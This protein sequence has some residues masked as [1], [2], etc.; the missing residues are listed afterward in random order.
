[1]NRNRKMIIIAALLLL[2]T[3]CLLFASC[4]LHVIH[5]YG[6][7]WLSD[8]T[9]HWKQCSTCDRQTA[10]A[11]H[12][13]AQDGWVVM[14]EP[15]ESQVGYRRGKCSVCKKVIEEEIEKIEHEHN[16][17]GEYKSDDLGHWQTCGCGASSDFQAHNVI[18]WEID[19]EATETTSGQKHG[20]CD[21]CG[22]YVT[23][24]IPIIGHEH[25]YS[26][27]L[28]YD[29]NYH[30]RECACGDKTEI[31]AHTYPPEWNRDKVNHWKE[32]A[33]GNTSAEQAHVTKWVIDKPA[34]TT[35]DGI[36]HEECTVCNENIRTEIIDKLTSEARTVDFYAINDFHGEVDK[37]STV[38]G[39]L[40]ECK[41]NNANTV[42][43]N[44]GDMFQGSMESNSNY[45][46][47][48]TDC[49]DAIG[50]DAFAFG[51]HEFDWG[52][53]KLQGLANNSNVPFLGANIYHWNASSKTWGT[54]AS[55]LAQEYTITTLDNGLRVG[56][57]GVIGEKQITSISSNLVQSIGF[58]NP[59]PIIKELATKLRG[60]QA[61]DVVVV[62]AHASP[63]GLLGESEGSNDPEEPSG[64]HDL[65]KY[66]DAVF[67]AHTH[68]EQNFLVDGLAFIQGSSYGS[69][70]S[71]IALSVNSNGDVSYTERENVSYSNSWP[72]IGIVDA[73]IDNSNAQ[74]EDERNQILAN[75][76]SNLNSNPQVPRLVC[77]AIADYAVSQ[78]YDITLA[79]TNT[80]R[81][82]VS[83]G[84]LTYSKLYEA[85]PFDNVV[86]I[87]KVS[88]RDLLNE[89][90]YKSYGDYANA[91]WR[92]KGEAISSGQ[93]YYIAV[94]DY[95]LFHQNANRDY[96][97][98]PSAFTSGFDPVPL[99][100]NNYEVY[101]YR[102][103]TRDFLLNSSDAIST[104]SYR[105]DNNHNDNSL[106]RSDVEIGS[107]SP[108]PDPA[109][110]PSHAGTIDDPYDVAD[111]IMVGAE[112]SSGGNAPSIYVRCIVSDVS[113]IKQS[114]TSGDLGSF[115]VKDESGATINVYYVSKCE[116]SSSANW[117][118]VND[119]KVGDVLLMCVSSYVY[120]GTPQLGYGY[121]IAIN[122]EPTC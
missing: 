103:I 115:Y 65:E 106:L 14:T 17:V 79:M 114:N 46:K 63:R 59:L 56:V 107:S 38:G 117:S 93:Y 110:A 122:G 51:N 44:S 62:T 61:C 50:F 108:S 40:K 42:L 18:K 33:C 5:N 57:I 41:N 92:V 47:L 24:I 116:Q 69:K 80:A 6:D 7:V 26:Q 43:I 86:Y 10:K 9:H 105:F 54:F 94:I 83:S 99:T 29:D 21:T 12:S 4:N 100:N 3:A 23:Q 81:S 53:D 113:S 39:Y 72:N 60:E 82:S 49:M 31:S 25:E 84:R 120:N 35:S 16:F 109:P 15:T 88:G 48:L 85:I 55:E 90:E 37:I 76:D 91:I 97:Y 36:K 22:K 19:R 118:S 28:S 87:A 32:C 34:T 73:L 89:A 70:V 58:K 71:H 104:S 102:F 112:Y 111:A 11:E 20:D 78:G 64:A 27:T 45:G 66:V 52:L 67:C 74:I 101:N 95:L 119:L 77:N 30:Y 121:C 13:V 75:L 96:N 1:M 2:F 98:F 68:R 8:E